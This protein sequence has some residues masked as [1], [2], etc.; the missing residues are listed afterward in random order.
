MSVD[1]M[2]N[3]KMDFVP[4]ENGRIACVK[5]KIC[6]IQGLMIGSVLSENPDNG[7]P[8][9]VTY[10]LP[11]KGEEYQP[12]ELINSKEY[13]R[14]DLIVSSNPKQVTPT[15]LFRMMDSVQYYLDI[16]RCADALR[17]TLKA[18]TSIGACGHLPDSGFFKL[19]FDRSDDYIFYINGYAIHKDELLCVLA[20]IQRFARGFVFLCPERDNDQLSETADMLQEY[21]KDMYHKG[22]WRGEA[23]GKDYFYVYGRVFEKD[24][25]N[26]KRMT[27]K[28]FETFYNNVTRIIHPVIKDIC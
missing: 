7:I 26:P 14:F 11:L 8:E 12:M 21:M 22:L 5:G 25:M 19:D 3:I 10:R 20:D 23:E 15:E 18:L 9:V 2:N 17:T 16:E 4:F 1:D 28:E 27:F 6:Q 24:W 13:T